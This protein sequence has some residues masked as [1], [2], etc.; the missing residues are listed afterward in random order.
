MMAATRPSCAAS[1][2]RKSVRSI[3]PSPPHFTTA[4]R[5]PASTALAALVP[6]ADSGIKHT[7]RPASARE[8]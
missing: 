4:T 6:C 7:S 5:R 1:L 3:A 2:A 8:A